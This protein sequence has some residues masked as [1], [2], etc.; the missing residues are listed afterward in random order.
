MEN[1]VTVVTKYGR[2]NV[3]RQ[4]LANDLNFSARVSKHLG[5][6]PGEPTNLTK[7]TSDPISG[8]LF[9]TLNTILKTHSK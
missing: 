5:R 9:S 7:T 3:D 4:K 1:L 8:E 6:R 2:F